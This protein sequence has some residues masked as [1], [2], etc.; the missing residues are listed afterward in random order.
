MKKIVVILT[1]VVLVGML[2]A[3]SFYG[4]VSKPTGD[5]ADDNLYGDDIGLAKMGFGAGLQIEKP[6]QNNLSM[7]FD[8]MFIYNSFDAD[9]IEDELEMESWDEYD[10]DVSAYKNIPLMGGLK[11]KMPN[12]N[13]MQFFGNFQ[14]GLNILIPPKFEEYSYEYDGYEYECDSETTF[15]TT[16]SFCYGI[17]GGCEMNNLVFEIKYLNLGKVDLTGEMEATYEVYDG[18]YYIYTETEDVELEGIARTVLL[19]TIGVK[20]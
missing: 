19:L 1:L 4:F 11:Y 8:G 18:G 15:D 17:G 9:E 10:L 14:L 13:G 7:I 2:Q 16:T 12:S 6:M 3:N 20:F 5:F